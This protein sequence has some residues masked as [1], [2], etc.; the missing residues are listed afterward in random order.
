MG[1]GGIFG[2]GHRHSLLKYLI[3]RSLPFRNHHSSESITVPYSS[4]LSSDLR[5]VE[6]RKLEHALEG[7]RSD[8]GTSPGRNWRSWWRRNHLQFCGHQGM[9]EVARLNICCKHG[10]DLMYLV[11]MRPFSL[12]AGEVIQKCIPTPG[13][14]YLAARPYR[15]VFPKFT[16]YHPMSP[17]ELRP[18]PS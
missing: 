2:G 17:F 14:P 16:Q 4:C 15:R 11:P 13:N 3:H 1:E 5:S 7:W 6:A 9:W 8:G 12:T 18:S 10:V